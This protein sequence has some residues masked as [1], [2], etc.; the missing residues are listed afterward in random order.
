MKE[1]SAYLE[2]GTKY[3]IDHLRLEAIG[4]LQELF[5]NNWD[6]FNRFKVGIMNI[7][8]GNPKQ[9]IIFDKPTRLVLQDLAT[10]I[11]FGRRF[12][13]SSI[14]PTAFYWCA[15]IPEDKLDNAFSEPY[16]LSRED[17]ERCM[18]G[19]AE[20]HKKVSLQRSFL[21][22][23]TA[24]GCS[25]PQ[26]CKEEIARRL[27]L[28]S[29]MT[30]PFWSHAPLY[31]SSLIEAIGMCKNCTQLHVRRYEF[32]RGQVWA[33]LPEIFDLPMSKPGSG[34]QCYGGWESDPEPDE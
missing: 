8:K 21:S 22:V 26:V 14:L 20:L 3:G 23:A 34:W 30:A 31:S 12:G 24:D 7:M 17:L 2:L 4:R 11:Y 5:P 9:A 15:Q 25:Q 16:K 32:I 18:V 27:H 10:V 1:I 6:N 13:V 29:F 33:S 19:R 28:E